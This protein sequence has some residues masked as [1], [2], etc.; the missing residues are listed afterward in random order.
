MLSPRWLRMFLRGALAPL[1]ITL[2]ASC[3]SS[4]QQSATL[5]QFIGYPSQYGVYV[6][7]GSTF[8]PIDNNSNHRTF[9]PNLS[10]L[11]FQKW[12]AEPDAKIESIKI[13]DW[14]YMD[15]TPLPEIAADVKLIGG[16]PGMLM[17]VPKQPL[18]PSL[19]SI[20]IGTGPEFLFG[21]QTDNEGAFWNS[22]L[23]ER[24]DSW[25]AHNHLGAVLYVRGDWKEAMG[26]FL[27]ATQLNPE[28]PESHNNYGLTLSMA[29]QMDQ[30]IE[31]YKL[32][33]RI[34]D[35]SAMETNLANAYQQ[36]GQTDLAIKAYNHAIELNP[37]NASA[38]CNLGYV[39]MR[40][41]QIDAAIAAFRRA[42][43]LDPQMPQAKSDL[44]RALE[45]KRTGS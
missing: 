15:A 24:P 38:Y 22:V 16:R 27:R 34:K 8:T 13:R 45:I 9:S 29:G 19:Y 2:L 26:H 7:D 5:P 28:N 40:K 23:D 14:R 44:Q 33:V 36:T 6:L 35:D 3:H 18:A 4:H 42:T 25:Q 37:E 41:G 43:Q 11:L 1:A 10:I 20:T 32:A 39:L 30:A 31:Q 12:L 17:L 21:V